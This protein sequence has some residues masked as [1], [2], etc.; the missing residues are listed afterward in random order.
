M[1]DPLVPD[2]IP[3]LIHRGD[4]HQ[5]TMIFG[6]LDAQL[7]VDHRARI[8]DEAVRGMDLSE[9][10]GAIASTGWE[11]GRPA[12]DPGVLIGLWLLA[13][14]DGY[15]SA[16]ELARL[17]D[18]HIAYRWLAH[19]MGIS[20]HTLSSF[21]VGHAAKLDRLLTQL[22]AALVSEGLVTMERVAQD[23]MRVRAAAGAAS[24]HRQTTLAAALV[25]AEAQVAELARQVE[26]RP[27]EMSARQRAARE[28][29]ARE[30]TERISNALD[31]AMQ[32][33]VKRAEKDGPARA[34]STDP[35]A[36]VMKQ[37]DGGFRPSL[38]VQLATDA[39]SQVIVGVAVTN[40]GSDLGL[41]APMHDQVTERTGILPKDYLIDGGFTKH[42][43]IETM[44]QAG[45]R[46]IAP[47]PK[48]KD[49]N[50][51]PHRPRP[52]D[53]PAVAAWRI[54]MGDEAVKVLYHLR[55]ATAECVN[56]LFRNR[57]MRALTVR[58]LDKSYSCALWQ[59]LAH[60]LMRAAVLRK[61]ATV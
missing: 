27:D 57:G 24:F 43:D 39:E 61:P 47:V 42:D 34:S 15:G 29:A 23:G 31:V 36:R 49:Q 48:P 11:G 32:L 55:A 2:G 51:D 58:G 8:V 17:V 4:R 21:R 53:S 44:D 28:R 7:P 38:N 54:R 10:Y 13:T 6:S 9:F 59:V 56:A 30:R 33:D 50:R 46:V 20:H 3:R 37:G 22:V 52:G 26:A 41:A 1:T 25:E 16:R 18:E 40:A 45:T 12:H 35:E 14:L 5:E 60:N 19:G